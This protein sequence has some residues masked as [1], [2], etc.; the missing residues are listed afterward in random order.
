VRR[1]AGRRHSPQARHVARTRPVKRVLTALGVILALIAVTGT[2]A[3]ALAY[4]RLNGNIKDVDI[5]DQLGPDRPEKVAEPA[6]D[7]EAL[8]ILVMGSDRRAGDVSFGE[9]SDTTILVHLAADRQSAAMVSIPRDTIVDIPECFTADGGTVAPREDEMFNT[10]FSEGGP[11]CTVRT[12]EALTDI[13]IDNY[14]VVDFRG[15]KDMVNALGGVEVCVPERV[16]DPK[17]R[18]DLRAGRQTVKGRQALAY[19]RTRYALGNGGDLDRI[20]RQQAFLASM[21]T[22]VKSTGLLLRPDRLFRFLDAATKSLTTDIGSLNDLR[23]L[24]QEVRGVQTRDVTFLTAPNEPYK[25]DPNRVQLK[26]AA[27]DVW[28]ALRFDQPLPGRDRAPSA[29]ASPSGP[30]L[31]TPPERVSVEVLNGS[32][33][34]GEASRV[35]RELTAAGFDVVGVGNADRTDYATTTVRHDPAY[36]ES[37]RTLGAAIAGSTVTEDLSLGSTL[38]VVVGAD[39]PTVSQVGVGAATPSPTPTPDERLKVRTANEDICR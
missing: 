25:G 31:V 26:P 39:R 18:L 13:R 20:D 37:G 30:P 35:A 29:T 33:I 2:A 22:K 36:D 19:V 32:G 23:R 21:V 15:F 3:A 9:R 38:V 27:K 12:V 34:T 8:N 6:E 16:Q 5:V 7:K 17:S 1:T 10:A 14:V 24:A 4:Y 28:T 11:A